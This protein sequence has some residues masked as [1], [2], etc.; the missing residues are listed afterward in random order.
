MASAAVLIDEI[1]TRRALLRRDPQRLASFRELQE[2]QVA[3]L[4][5]TYADLSANPRFAAALE[6]FV[7]DLYGPRDFTRRDRDLKNV[8]RQWEKLLPQRAL[9]ALIGALE[10]EALTLSL[11]ADTLD[12][13]A[14]RELDEAVYA[15]AYR[16]ADR[17][18]D[19]VRQISAI[20]AAGRDLEAL[21][22][23]PGIGIALRAAKVPAH[24]LGLD[25]LQDFLERGYRAFKRMGSAHE[26][27]QII[28]ERETAILTRLFDARRQPFR[29]EPSLRILGSG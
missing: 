5:R 13:V 29:V 2:W 4:R 16:R 9:R 24:A 21:V 12:C 7:S 19:R 6:F 17:R 1:A 11:D 15:D 14:G 26:L 27:L 8:L 25:E 23:V 10:L 22:K 3:R 18:Q 20:V 28:E